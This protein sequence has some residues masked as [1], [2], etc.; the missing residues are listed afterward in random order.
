MGGTISL[1]S[2]PGTGSAFTFTASLQKQAGTSDSSTAELAQPLWNQ[3]LLIV[4]DNQSCRIALGN[5]LNAWGVR[6]DCAET[7]PAALD[8]LRDAVQKNDPFSVVLLD[9][10]LP[11]MNGWKVAE[12]IKQSSQIPQAKVILLGPIESYAYAD[13]SHRSDYAACLTKPVSRQKLLECLITVVESSLPGSSPPPRGEQQIVTPLARFQANLLLVEDN[14]VNQE[15]TKEMLEALGCR[16]EVAESGKEA[17]QKLTNELYDLVLMDCQM[18]ELDGYETTR[19]IR[20]NLATTLPI[21]ALTALA[22]KGDRELCLAAGMN[23]YLSKPFSIRQ[24]EKILDR[25]LEEKKKPRDSVQFVKPEAGPG[26]EVEIK[27]TAEVLEAFVP[28]CTT[29]VLVA[30]DDPASQHVLKEMLEILG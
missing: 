20:A 12:R 1:L 27:T 15:V 22:M 11:E 25:W 29:P 23:D 26:G 5:L 3:H 17:L 28:A 4:D 2:E 14:P 24:L 16:V 18:P 10:T 9:L 30:E 13:A 6:H 19:L 21:V 8:M 7:G